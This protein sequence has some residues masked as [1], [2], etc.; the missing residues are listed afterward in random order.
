MEMPKPTKDHE[1]LHAFA[2]EWDSEET[3]MPSP[4]G[5]GSKATGKMKAHVDADGFFV[6]WDYV[7]EM[8]GVATYR[9]HGVYGFDP[10]AAEYTWY[11]FD[12]MGTASIR[13]RGKWEGDTLT[14]EHTNAYGMA[15]FIFRWEG[16]DKHHFHIEGSVD[17]KTWSTA[18]EATYTRR[19]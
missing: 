3:M 12:S 4:M 11:W 14:F 2:G 18:K 6:I 15:R 5:P 10:Q 13:S 9:G 7:Q 17:G 19:A 8:G 16:K 1:K